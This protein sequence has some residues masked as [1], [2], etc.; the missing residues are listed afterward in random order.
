MWVGRFGG[1]LFPASVD[2]LAL[3]LGLYLVALRGWR[4]AGPS[5]LMRLIR[6]VLA[7]LA[8]CFVLFS[9][10]VVVFGVFDYADCRSS[11]DEFHGMERSLLA[12]GCSYE[13]RTT[14][15]ALAVTVALGVL[16]YL[17]LRSR[18]RKSAGART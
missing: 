2:V 7:T 15:L 10:V 6:L 1:L 16:A 4:E 12:W 3:T 13:V 5:S 8:I 17:L 9:L 18:W 11:L 14:L